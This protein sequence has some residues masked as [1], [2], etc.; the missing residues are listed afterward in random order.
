MVKKVSDEKETKTTANIWRLTIIWQREIFFFFISN[1]NNIM[2]I[3]FFGV[4]IYFSYFI[5]CHLGL[6][7]RRSIA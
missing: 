1:L 2:M 5:P 3:V 6:P 4:K 7:I